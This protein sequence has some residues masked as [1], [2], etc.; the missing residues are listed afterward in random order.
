M[1]HKNKIIPTLS[2]LVNLNTRLK[3]VQSTDFT[4]NLCLKIYVED[5]NFSHLL[6]YVDICD[7]S[8]FNTEVLTLLHRISCLTLSVLRQIYCPE[9]SSVSGVSTLPRYQGQVEHEHDE[10]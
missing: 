3:S 2:L 6:Y 1:V 4:L 8:F 7:S 9:E 10:Q 5:C